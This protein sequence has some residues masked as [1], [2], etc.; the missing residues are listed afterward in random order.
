MSGQ[1]HKCRFGVIVPWMNRAVESEL[2]YTVPRDLAL[3]WA[4]VRPVV[5]PDGPDDDSYISSFVDAIPAAVQDLAPTDIHEIVVACT[6]VALV[7]PDMLSEWGLLGVTDCILEDLS[8]HRSR[9]LL[10]ASPYSI[11]LA[12]K[13]CDFLEESG[14]CVTKYVPI[15]CT[16]EYRDIAIEDIRSRILESSDGDHDSVVLS[17]TALHTQGLRKHLMLAGESRPL[18]SSVSAISAS[19]TDRC[20]ACHCFASRRSV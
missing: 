11:D 15:S 10:V 17:C 14:F 12:E 3:H 2:P 9:R 1:H 18:I 20:S 8:R 4:R 5:L 16:G 19:L 6:S 7:A 13:L